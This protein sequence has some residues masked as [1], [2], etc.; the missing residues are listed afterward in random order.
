MKKELKPVIEV[1]NLI[2]KYGERT[3]LEDISLDIY[4]GE[5]TVILGSSGG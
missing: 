3:I 5:V 2:A 4:Q 1:K